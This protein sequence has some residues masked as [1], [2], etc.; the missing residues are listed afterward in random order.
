MISATQIIQAMQPIWHVDPRFSAPNSL[1]AKDFKQASKILLHVDGG[2]G[3][4]FEAQW[5]DQYYSK[6]H[7]PTAS[8]TPVLGSELVAQAKD[9]W[10]GALE[11][12]AASQDSPERPAFDFASAG[13]FD[14][15]VGGD[16]NAPARPSKVQRVGDACEGKKM[17]KIQRLRES[18]QLLRCRLVRIA[19]T[20]SQAGFLR[21][22]QGV[23]RYIYNECVDMHNNGEIDGADMVEKR[24]V[25]SSLT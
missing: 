3:A 18:G 4:F 17:K 13:D 10:F 5:K 11:R 20:R 24:R 16:V 14:V 25:R 6:L 2:R 23:H 21:R 9:S 22:V 8:D 19:P 7:V 12:K 15:A 1:D